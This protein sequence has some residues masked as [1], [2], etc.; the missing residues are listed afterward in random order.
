MQHMLSPGS[1]QLTGDI[2]LKMSCSFYGRSSVTTTFLGTAE[3]LSFRL[4][5]STTYV[6]YM[7][8]NHAISKAHYTETV[9]HTLTPFPFLSYRVTQLKDSFPPLIIIPYELQNVPHSLSLYTAL[10]IISPILLTRYSYM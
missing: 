7:K 3:I 4:G 10:E 9:Y 6:L 5:Y 2:T 8:H 1:K